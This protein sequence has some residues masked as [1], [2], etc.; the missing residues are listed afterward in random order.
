MTVYFTRNHHECAFVAIERIVPGSVWLNE[1][2]QN[3]KAVNRVHETVIIPIWPHR[4]AFVSCFP[5]NCANVLH[6]SL[7]ACLLGL[8]ANGADTR[9]KRKL[10]INMIRLEIF[11]AFYRRTAAFNLWLQFSSIKLF[12][13]KKIF[14]FSSS[15]VGFKIKIVSRAASHFIMRAT[16]YHK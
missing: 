6:D 16:M 14:L 11:F 7:P 12:L 5:L 2:R 8:A 13:Q 15:S 4:S 3:K 1:Q 10:K 9:E